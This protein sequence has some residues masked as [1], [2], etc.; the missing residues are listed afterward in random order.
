VYRREG[1]VG[2]K[3]EGGKGFLGRISL[4]VLSL[5]SGI[6]ILTRF[7]KHGPGILGDFTLWQA[8]GCKDTKLQSNDSPIHKFVNIQ[9]E[10]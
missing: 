2:S 6:Y 8:Q 9:R 1:R 3:S 4:C 5:F 10:L 7:Q